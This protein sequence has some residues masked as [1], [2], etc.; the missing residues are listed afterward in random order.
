VIDNL[1]GTGRCYGMEMNV[2]KNKVMRISRQPS[3]IQVMKDQR[4]MDMCNIS[5]IWTAR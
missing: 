5:N 3:P 4:Q 2:G 1:I